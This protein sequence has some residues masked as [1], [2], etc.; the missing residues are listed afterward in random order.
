MSFAV[1]D[2]PWGIFDTDA[3][4]QSDADKLVEYARRKL[5]DPVL[6][7]YVSSSQIYTS[8]EEA[9]LEYSAIVNS[10][11]AKSV[12]AQFLGTPTGSLSG[13][14]NTY[15]NRTLDFQKKLAES[16]SEDAGLNG[17]HPLYSG[18]IRLRTSVQHYDLQE[19]L[20]GSGPLTGSNANAR[21]QVREV[22]HFSPV[23]A[24][25]F[26]GTTSALN[27]LNNQFSFESYTP[28]TIF[29][30]LPIWEDIL[31]GMQFETSNRVR[32]SQYSYSLANNVLTVYPTPTSDIDLW[33]KYRLP[34][35]PSTEGQHKVANLSNVPFGNIQYSKLNSIGK[36]WIRRFAFALVKETEG[37]LRRHMQTIPIPDGDL[38]LDGEQLV[39]EAKAEQDALRGELRELL[40]ELTYDKLAAREAELAETL[41]RTL[42]EVPLGIYI[43]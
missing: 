29:Y 13:S 18:S 7:V 41:K 36:Q 40:D 4:F 19:L 38:T 24:Y 6:E 35:T 34:S 32:R 5:G 12:L 42:A 43:G 31:R 16:Y 22:L 3:Q 28:E 21:I 37:Y 27:Y 15:V 26:F 23:S 11:Q 20:S 10:Y 39:S 9:C 17:P 2:T 1:G 14:E 25:R 8:F 30:L 33:I